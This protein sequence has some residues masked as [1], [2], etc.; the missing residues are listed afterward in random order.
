MN[1]HGKGTWKLEPFEGCLS[2]YTNTP[3]S[4]FH[5][6]MQR[7]ILGFRWTRE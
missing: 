7:L 4:W 5:R 1:I 3:P 2:F 6:V